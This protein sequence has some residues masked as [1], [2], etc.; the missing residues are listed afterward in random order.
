VERTVQIVERDAEVVCIIG[1]SAKG[2]IE[3]IAAIT[4]EATQ[5]F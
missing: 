3:V 4:K 5:L 2:E 1:K